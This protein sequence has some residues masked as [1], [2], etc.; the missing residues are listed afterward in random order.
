MTQWPLR[1]H[2]HVHVISGNTKVI[3]PQVMCAGELALLECTMVSLNHHRCML[4]VSYKH[5]SHSR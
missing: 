3:Y 1:A 4:T 2:L 5:N